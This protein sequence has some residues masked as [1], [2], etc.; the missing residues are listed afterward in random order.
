MAAARQRLDGVRC[1]RSASTDAEQPSASSPKPSAGPSRRA[2]A[3]RDG[4]PL[5]IKLQTVGRPYRADGGPDSSVLHEC[6]LSTTEEAR[7][8]RTPSPGNLLGLI[9]GRSGIPADW[10]TQLE[11]RDVIERVGQD[12]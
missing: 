8:A 3:R 4:Q 2:T 9:H 5:P 1:S 10:L 11:L 6:W 7:T 12:L